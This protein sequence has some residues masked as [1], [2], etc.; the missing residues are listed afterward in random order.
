MKNGYSADIFDRLNILNMGLQGPNT[1][2]FTVN[3]KITSF[4][5]KL[6]LFI[7]QARNNDFSSFLTLS[8]FLE[9]N[10]LTPVEDLV[11]DITV[12]LQG[13]QDSFNKYFPEDYSKY[14][15]I[16]NPFS[17]EVPQD[18]IAKECF[19]DMT[20]D[21]SMKDSFK[22]KTLSFWMGTKTEYP[23]LFKQALSFLLPFV[24]TYMCESGFSELLYTKN[25]YRNRLSIEEDLRVKLSSIEPN[26]DVLYVNKQHA[27][28]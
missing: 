17:G 23:S 12:H 24:T 3:D 11:P 6:T 7:S 8:S 28:N 4:K 16:R 21:S 13:L 14:E 19:I 25:K 2:V 22:D 9:E 10:E 20:S 5:R 18:V 27:S 26:I 15:W 1:T